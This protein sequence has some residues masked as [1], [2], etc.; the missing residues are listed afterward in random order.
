MEDN[1][2]LQVHPESQAVLSSERTGLQEQGYQKIPAE[3]MSGGHIC[4]GNE[5]V[6]LLNRFPEIPHKILQENQLQAGVSWHIW[7]SG[8]QGRKY[9]QLLLYGECFQEQTYCHLVFSTHMLPAEQDVL[10]LIQFRQHFFKIP[11]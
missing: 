8:L 5:W 9:Q 2:R 7:L 6:R 1:T 4:Q 3:S 11:V 10:R